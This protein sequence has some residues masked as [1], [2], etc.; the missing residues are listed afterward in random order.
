MTETNHVA[1]RIETAAAS[2]RTDRFRLILVNCVILFALALAVVPLRL[3]RLSELPPGVDAG[4]GAN[5]LDAL[6]VLQGEHAVFFPEKFKGREGLAMYAIALSI[7]I[8]G[9]TEF[10]LRLPT[11]LA[12][13]ATVLVVFWLGTLLFGRDEEGGRAAPWRGVAIGGAA[14]GLMA[15]SLGQTAMGRNAFRTSWLPLFLCL[16]LAF[17]WLGWSQ[18]SRGGRAWWWLVLAGVCIGLLPYTY[19]PARLVPF[20]LLTFGLSFLLPLRAVARET[21]GVSMH[22]TGIAAALARGRAEMPPIAVLVAV[23]GLVAAPILVHFALHPEHFLSRS[24]PLWVFDPSNS[25]GN[26]LVTFL[27]NVLDHLL[28]FGFRGDPSWMYNF[29]SR[30]FLNLVEAPFF[31]L[32]VSIAV[33]HWLRQ[34]AYRLLLL[35]LFF[36]IVPALLSSEG[37]PN[38]LRM[39]GAAPAVYLLIGV[40]MWEAFQYLKKRFFRERD[41]GAALAAG[42]VLGALILVQGVRTYF[43][44]FQEWAAAPETYEEYLPHWTELALMLNAQPSTADSIFLIPGHAYYFRDYWQYT[45][46]YLYLGTTSTRYISAGAFNLAPA[47]EATLAEMDNKSNVQ[48]VDWDNAIVGGDAV[49]EEQIA[50]L[51]EKYGRYQ[52]SKEGTSFQIHSYTDISLERPWTVYDRLEP[53]EVH[54]DG[55]ISLLGLARGQGADQLTLQQPFRLSEDKVMWVAMQWQTA[56]ELEIEYSISL[57]LH[58]TEGGVVYQQDAVLRDPRSAST[59]Y[60]SAGESVDT[61]HFLDVPADMAPGAYEMRMVVYDFATMKP[62]VEIGIWEPETVL[63]QLRLEEAQ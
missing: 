28:A 5:G 42:L 33:W 63:A 10:A 9:R 27:V 38:T 50:L 32:G 47:V 46:G 2:V 39:S 62:T 49:A 57:R 15:V 54:F 61:L 24:R 11:A 4:E 21:D 30:P 16:G 31:W 53:L 13:A 37:P 36:L 14:A 44:Y 29:A 17:L 19:I 3:H 51:L 58:N 56:P 59:R 45:F 60:W 18:R 48:Y 34:P 7:S 52:G 41:T 20:L 22:Q 6:R 23:A 55:G 40:G 1:Q 43:T 12:S 35:W 8:F 26:P 25:Q